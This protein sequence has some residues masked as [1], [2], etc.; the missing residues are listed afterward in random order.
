[1]VRDKIRLGPEAALRSESFTASLIDSPYQLVL[2]V[3]SSAN[4]SLV[5]L[6]SV[7]RNHPKAS[8]GFIGLLVIVG[9]SVS[10][11]HQLHD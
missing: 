9:D 7:S 8:V 11:V 5:M 6:S 3:I 10:D 1:M 2:R 4:W